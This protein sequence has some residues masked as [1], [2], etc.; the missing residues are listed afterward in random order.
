MEFFFHIACILFIAGFIIIL[1]KIYGINESYLFFIGISL[2]G[3]SICLAF[4]ILI[5]SLFTSPKF[6]NVEQTIEN[7]L[8]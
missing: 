2:I 1:I 4:L 7:K 6:I 8:K 3:V 5:K